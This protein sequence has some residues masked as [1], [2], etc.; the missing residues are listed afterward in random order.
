MLDIA[1]FEYFQMNSF[2]QFCINYCNEKLQNFF[3][4]HILNDEQQLYENE[5]LG[6]KRIDYMDNRD[7]IELFE[8]R[9]TGIFDLLDEE[10]RLPK[11]SAQHFTEMVHKTNRGKFRLDVPRKSKLKI[12][13]E[14]IDDEGF[15]IRHFAGAVCYQTSQFLD[16]NNDSLHTNLAFLML[17]SNNKIL[18]SFFLMENNN[19]TSNNNGHF[20]AQNF[21]SASLADKSVRLSL[22]SVGSKF[23]KQLND[24][25]NKLEST[26]THFIRC[27]KPNLNMVAH[28][29]DGGCILSQLK[30]SGM[31]SVLQLMQYGFPSRAT[32]AHIYDLYS[33]RLPKRLSLIE[34]R[35]FCHALIKAVGLKDTD[36]CF[37]VTKVFFRPGRFAEFDMLLKNDDP[38]MMDQLVKK[39]QHWLIA[40]RW[41]RAQWCSLS[42]IKCKLLELIFNP[43]FF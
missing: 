4:E 36:V 43:V 23:R 35:F 33:P 39:V 37:G 11:A 7:C 26:G 38:A 42:V 29:F 24:L 27:I 5:G 10:S 30:C 32:Y 20:V 41:R 17:E 2:E 12:Y 16:K 14:L 8:A 31:A 13:R 19:S 15:I 28:E 18:K 6:I 22:E 21:S 34:P 3:N 25:I 9:G 1:G 40:S